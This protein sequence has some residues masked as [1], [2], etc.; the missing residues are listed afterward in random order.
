MQDLFREISQEVNIIS[1]LNHPSILK[2]IFSPVNFKQKTKPV[3]ITE[4]APNGSL[5]ENIEHNR[6]HRNN[7]FLNDTS[8]LIII[9]G[10]VSAMS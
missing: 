2:L 8:K 6:M 10:I 9:I 5:L 3:I 7:Q 1:K 4:Y